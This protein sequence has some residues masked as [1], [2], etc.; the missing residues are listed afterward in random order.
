MSAG[1]R[2]YTTSADS[3][4]QGAGDITITAATDK[5]L[6]LDPGGAGRT[7][8]L[9]FV[10]T[11]ET[12]VTTSFAEVFIDN[13]AD[14]AEAFTVRDGNNSDSALCLIEQNKM[15]HFQWTGAKWVTT[16]GET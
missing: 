16:T 13:V 3:A 6:T 15:A 10:D 4:T 14:A 12:G 5:I 1:T 8:D 7:I 2:Q 9:V 11:A